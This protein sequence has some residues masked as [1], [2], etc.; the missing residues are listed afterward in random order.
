MCGTNKT[1][2][3]TLQTPEQAPARAATMPLVARLFR[4][5]IRNHTGKIIVAAICMAIVAATTA[6]NAWVMQ[7]V[8][9]EVFLN[10]NKTMLLILPVVI[11]A[12]AVTKGVA[13][14]FQA[15]LM[16]V[17]GQRIIAEV[18]IS[19]FA[20]LMRADLAYFN[21]TATGRLISNFLNDVNLLREAL[22]KALTGIAKDSLMVLALAGVMFYQ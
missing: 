8:L 16:S 19:L 15:Y 7:P 2:T 3:L 1:R 10:R 12:I 6:V 9:D 18:Q 17:V 4:G 13:Q 20:H 14:Y 22:T 5:Y 21:S 11:L